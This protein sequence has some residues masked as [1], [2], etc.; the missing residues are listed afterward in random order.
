MLEKG[1]VDF[2]GQIIQLASVK[3]QNIP[4]FRRETDL[5]LEVQG[6]LYRV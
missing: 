4:V 2:Y 1:T 3:P 5:N 6:Q